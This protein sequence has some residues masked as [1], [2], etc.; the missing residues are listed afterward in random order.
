MGKIK[1]VVK[2][3][4][5]FLLPC[6]VFWAAAAVAIV[7]CDKVPL[8]IAFNS[9]HTPFQNDVWLAVT[10]LG[11]S[12]FCI[13]VLLT[14]TL[15]SYRYMV[16]GIVSI[17]IAMGITTLLKYAI[18]MPRPSVELAQAGLLGGMDLVEGYSLRETLS[19]PSGHT[20]A[21]FCLFTTL[22][23]FA[24]RNWVKVVL[25][26]IAFGVAY[27]RIYLMQHF[28]SDVLAGSVIGTATAVAVYAYVRDARW[29][30]FGRPLVSPRL[31]GWKKK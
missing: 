30:D 3:N 31:Y 13:C 29:I 15:F 19:F 16:S 9:L 12:V 26:L 23:L 1:D 4:I 7:F 20:T 14:G 6:L 18:E 17:L 25:F 24:R 27:S 5:P 8:Q 10:A 21:A 28:L 11:G 2:A 22:A